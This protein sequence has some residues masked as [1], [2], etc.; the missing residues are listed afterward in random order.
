[1]QDSNRE[2]LEHLW[3]ARIK[4]ARLRLAFARHYVKELQRD[5]PDAALEGHFE[6]H[7]AVREERIA[8][9]EFNRVLW[10]YNDLVRAGKIPDES[11][12]RKGRE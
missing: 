5:F 10:V 1:M 4:D 6:Y 7:R 12:W 11:E 2:K 8:L 3:A 9:A